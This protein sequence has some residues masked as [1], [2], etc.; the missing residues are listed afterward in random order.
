[1]SLTEFSVVVCL[2]QRNLYTKMN[3]LCH[4]CVVWHCSPLTL[5]SESISSSLSVSHIYAIC[6]VCDLRRLCVWPLLSLL[7]T[8]FGLSR[9]NSSY[10]SLVLAVTVL[11]VFCLRSLS[12]VLYSFLSLVVPFPLL[13][14]LGLFYS[15]LAC[16][17]SPLS[18]NLCFWYFLWS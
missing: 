15:T 11:P 10:S 13:P 1:M 9:F 12:L 17:W 7:L 8:V 14:V 18:L 3:D 4:G 16:L 5:V 2:T 6:H